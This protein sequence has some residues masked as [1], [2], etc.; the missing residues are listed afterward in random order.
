MPDNRSLIL[1]LWLSYGH[2]DPSGAWV[3]HVHSPGKQCANF[4]SARDGRNRACQSHVRNDA[5]LTH[6]DCWLAGWKLSEIDAV[7]RE[8][9]CEV[10]SNLILEEYMTVGDCS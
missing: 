6:A 2:P 8:A 10:W 3:P 5:L 4:L 1:I 9:V 7:S